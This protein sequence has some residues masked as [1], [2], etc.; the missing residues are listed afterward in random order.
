MENGAAKEVDKLT[1]IDKTGNF[2]ESPF[3]QRAAG[4]ARSRDIDDC[5]SARRF[6]LRRWRIA[7]CILADQ[8]R[9]GSFDNG[10]ADANG[11]LMDTAHGQVPTGVLRLVPVLRPWLSAAARVPP[12]TTTA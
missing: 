2:T 9:Y 3:E 10:G 4:T 1:D 12:V 11:P 6:P 8:A 7:S 5:D